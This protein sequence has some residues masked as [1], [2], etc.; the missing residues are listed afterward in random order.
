M[1][2]REGYKICDL[3]YSQVGFL[4]YEQY[5]FCTSITLVKNV[6]LSYLGQKLN[7]LERDCFSEKS[8]TRRQKVKVE[9][10]RK[11]VIIAD[12]K[13][14]YV[15]LGVS[16]NELIDQRSGNMTSGSNSLQY[17]RHERK[18]AIRDFSYEENEFQEMNVKDSENRGQCTSRINENFDILM[19][20][21]NQRLDFE[22]NW[23]VLWAI[24]TFLQTDCGFISAIY[25]L[26]LLIR[27][28]VFLL[29][30]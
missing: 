27:A 5:R 8:R 23:I 11:A 2:E 26:F 22:W 1:P 13:N 4:K 19:G 25:W 24:K 17:N 28:I 3:R 12:I 21:R 10:S 15:V 30:T 7:L 14:M 29:P 20:E 9:R 16:E 18:R 6:E